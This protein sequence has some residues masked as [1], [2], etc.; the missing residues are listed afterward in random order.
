VILAV[1]EEDH[2]MLVEQF[3]VPLGRPASNFPP[4]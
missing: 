1:D 3:R 2:V 4:A